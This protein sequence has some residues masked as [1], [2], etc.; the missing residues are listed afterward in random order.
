MA[1]NSV[2]INNN[3][4]TNDDTRTRIL[5]ATGI[6]RSLAGGPDACRPA[7]LVRPRGCGWQSQERE[8]GE[9]KARKRGP[10]D[11]IVMAAIGV[12]GQGTGIMKVGQG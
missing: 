10:N 8:A 12:G 11:Q 5:V 7:A 6:S 3:E 1:S 9:R 2:P 4:E